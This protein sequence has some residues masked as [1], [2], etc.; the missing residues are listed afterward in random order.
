MKEKSKTK[1]TRSP[2]KKKEHGVQTI[3]S[4]F[5]KQQ[6]ANTSKVNKAKVVMCSSSTDDDDAVLIT[7]TETVSEYFS[8]KEKTSKFVNKLSLR[9]RQ[10]GED[11]STSCSTSNRNGHLAETEKI[12]IERCDQT[13][14]QAEKDVNVKYE[15]SDKTVEAD[16]QVWSS[17]VNTNINSNKKLSLRKRKSSS[18][19][20]TSLTQKRLK[21]NGEICEG[22]SGQNVEKGLPSSN[23]SNSR[24][25]E[26]ERDKETQN[27]DDPVNC[28][29]T[30]SLTKS[31]S[32][33][34]DFH[35]E[36]ENVIR[37]PYYLENFRTIICTILSCEDNS[38][39]FNDDDRKVVSVFE[40]LTEP[41]QKLYVRLF[42]RKWK[43][44]TQQQ[45][46]YPE[47]K[48]D[49]NAVFSE[50]NQ[51]G[52]L[53]NE[54]D[55]DDL[56][57]GL[58][59]LPAPDLKSFAK[60]YH[61]TSIAN[62][63]TIIPALLKKCTG[64]TI[65]SMF[66]VSGHDPH[67]VMLKRVKK[68]LGPCVTLREEPRFV[69]VRMIMLFSLTDT[70]LDDDNA[71]AGQSQLFRML[72][73]NIGDTV[74]P[75]FNVNRETQIFKDR[76]S[77]LRFSKACLMEAD[78]W[79]KLEKN[80]F[81][82][83]YSVYIEAK[84]RVQELKKDK[85]LANYDK[86]LPDFLRPFTA[87]SVYTRIINQ[88][89]EL[90]QRRKEYTQAVAVLRKLLSQQVYCVDYRGHWWE[91]L[92]LNYDAHLKNQEKAL[93]AVE[94]GLKDPTVMAGRRLALYLRAEKICTVPKSKFKNRMKNLPDESVQAT[95]EV[96]IEGTVLSDNMP[97]MR[98][99]FIM[100]DPDGDEDKLTFCG[101]EELVLEHYK[102]NGYP[103]G[104]HAEG[105][106]LSNLFG[107]FFWDVLFM[108]VPDVFH[109]A[110]Q[111][112]PLDLY[113]TL[114]YTNRKSAIDQLLDEI[115]KA[116]VEELHTMMTAVWE[117]HC[118]VM[119]A[120]LN[121]ER[122]SCL[123]HAQVKTPMADNWLSFLYWRQKTVPDPGAVCEE[124]QTHA[125]RVS[126]LDLVESTNRC[127]Q[128][129]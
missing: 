77:V 30:T 33:K 121:W 69:F 87:L 118:G 116:T 88:G 3:T 60:T 42:G 128:D 101:V 108:D 98:Y 99:K 36:E 75:T 21:T 100:A 26:S 52:F 56:E 83:A 44:L 93:E 25:T 54:N 40:E 28:P 24:E 1:K 71:N 39:L 84:E 124:S 49:L 97:G 46:K 10:I 11:D 58:N 95:P 129:M 117:A 57:K 17:S 34:S 2:Q 86:T 13:E 37:T 15:V 89:V 76:E 94:N 65:G 23:P 72:Q 47:I 120:G 61:L 50:L 78:L 79:S 29:V 80:D 115:N 81:E 43:W 74:Y 20:D 104:L 85:G 107:L 16:P 127:S 51:Q 67:R 62:K 92:A 27:K 112:H 105:S 6:V 55:F 41:A 102:N 123:S 96:C 14:S 106:I 59:L 5:K 19:E 110:Y 125:V 73:V 113:S 31:Y 109:S 63:K 9:K 68:L 126:R 114:F 35:G 48:A 119:C 45:I 66:K 18:V 111:T 8:P 32:V 53:M 22:S 64:N 90:L 82:G 38:K 70:I 122:F 7:H 91:R 4:M 12:N 103:E